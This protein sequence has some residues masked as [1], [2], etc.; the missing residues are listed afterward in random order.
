MWFSCLFLWLAFLLSCCLLLVCS[1]PPTLRTVALKIVHTLQDSHTC[2]WLQRVHRGLSLWKLYATVTVE[3]KYA[4]GKKILYSFLILFIC[5]RNL[6]Q[7]Q[8]V[9]WRFILATWPS[10]ELI[11]GFSFTGKVTNGSNVHICI[12]KNGANLFQG[13]ECWL[14]R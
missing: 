13:R 4:G 1:L 7:S 5:G 2:F 8:L 14:S 11:M 12:I 10:C 3:I 9:M 6:I